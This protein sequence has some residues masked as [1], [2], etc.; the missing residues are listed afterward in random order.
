MVESNMNGLI[1]YYDE[2]AKEY[3]EVYMGKF[4]FITE[5]DPYKKE[6]EELNKKD[7][8]ETIKIVSK[9]GKGYLIDIGCGTGFWI[10]YY[11]KNCDAIT[12][13]DDSNKMLSECRKR[14]LELDIE[15]KCHFTKGDFF[16]LNFKNYKF[17]SAIAGFFISHLFPDVDESFFEKLKNILKKDAVFLFIDSSWSK[18]RSRYREKE[19]FQERILND[20]RKF[21]IYKRYFTKEEVR[22]IF[23]KYRFKLI[24]FYF[25]D[26]FFAVIGEN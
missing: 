14:V 11:E 9:F 7:I 13:I 23:K 8:Q 15:S 12:L 22:F 1:Q 17:D 20:G 16:S 5:S 2:R 3:D 6:A 19:G 21:T 24:S 18:W 4:P 25:G 10:P 26:A